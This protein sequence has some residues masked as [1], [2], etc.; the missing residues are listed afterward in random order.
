MCTYNIIT[1]FQAESREVSIQKLLSKSDKISLT[2]VDHQ[3]C[4]IY[5]MKSR[6]SVKTNNT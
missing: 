2:V 5:A 3:S 6:T 1:H 4:S